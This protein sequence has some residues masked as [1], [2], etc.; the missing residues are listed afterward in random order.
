MSKFLQDELKASEQR[1]CDTCQ[2]PNRDMTVLIET[3]KFYNIGTQTMLNGETKNSLCLRCNSNLNSPSRNDSPY[4]MKLL[5][6][7]GSITDET[8]STTSDLD[9]L[10]DSKLL[11]PIKKDDLL[12][13]PILGHHRISERMSQQSIPSAALATSPLILSPK[14]TTLTKSMNSCTYANDLSFTMSDTENFLTNLE[15]LKVE[16]NS[17]LL[18]NDE[19][20][21]IK[22]NKSDLGKMPFDLP[23]PTSN[24]HSNNSNSS[25][26]VD[27]VKTA[28]ATDKR[29]IQSGSGSSVKSNSN[30]LQHG[31]GNGSTNSLW[32]KTSSKEGNKMFEHFNRNL[33]KTI[34][35]SKLASSL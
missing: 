14:I 24:I 21:E 34:K 7:N 19:N 12:V 6:S 30:N 2:C 20:I 26:S 22:S 35:V 1:H 28:P 5:K 23:T 11:S 25:P 8:K 13:N 18:N 4:I 29:T 33:I 17:I 31:I 10:S 32:S 16:N 9:P 27:G 3:P 15:N